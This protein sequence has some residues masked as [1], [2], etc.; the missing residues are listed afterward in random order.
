MFDRLYNSAI[1]AIVAL[2]L[3]WFLVGLVIGYFIGHN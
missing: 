2:V 3:T 1:F